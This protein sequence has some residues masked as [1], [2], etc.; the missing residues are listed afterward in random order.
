[1]P[2]LVTA[3]VLAALALPGGALAHGSHGAGLK[4][5]A[6]FGPWDAGAKRPVFRQ[7]QAGNV[8]F[9]HPMLGD[10]GK[11][12]AAGPP[13]PALR[14]DPDIPE[15]VRSTANVIGSGLSANPL[16]LA[17][18]VYSSFL[19]KIDGP[20][21]QHYPTCSRFANQAVARYGVM[22]VV[23]GLDRLIQD[24]HSSSLRRLPEL[25]VGESLRHYD[26]VENYEFWSAAKIKA[27]P[28]P[29]PEEPLELPALEA[30]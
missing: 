18:L 9:A 22:G 15:A 23:L 12:P 1:M 7:G 19:T 4:A 26:P 28:K 5:R 30:R 25:D 24:D 17:A 27:F 10:P 3:L 13:P 8:R 2:R 16:F 11:V 20:R 21:C 14:I 6:D 29:V